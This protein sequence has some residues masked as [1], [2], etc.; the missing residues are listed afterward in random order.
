MQVQGAART[1]HVGDG[2][3][4]AQLYRDLDRTVQADHCRVNTAGRQVFSHQVG[5]CGGDAPTG[6]I[7]D[8]PRG[9]T[10]PL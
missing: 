10:K 5:V 8:F 2:V 7:V 9:E 4:D 6:Q 1:H 3:G